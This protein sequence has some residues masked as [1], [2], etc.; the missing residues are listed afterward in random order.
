MSLN[1]GT[2]MTCAA[3]AGGGADAARAV[4][5]AQEKGQGSSCISHTALTVAVYMY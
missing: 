3:A 5:I 1:A 4:A 2:A